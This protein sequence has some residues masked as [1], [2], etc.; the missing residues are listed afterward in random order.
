[1]ARSFFNVAAFNVRN[2]VNAE[3]TYYQRSRYSQ[4][5]Y[6]EKLT[7]L[8]EQLY[9]LDADFVCMQ[10]VFHSAALNDLLA[11][12]DALLAARHSPTKARLD[13][14]DTVH[15][16]PNI[17]E[18]ANNPQP[19]LAFLS[20]RTVHSYDAVQDL[21]ARPI[22]IPDDDGFSYGLTKLSRPV[23]I[24]KVDL[25]KGVSG[26]IFNAHLKSKLPRFPFGDPAADE[27]NALFLARTT[28]VFRSLALRAGEALAVR[29]E[30]LQRSQNS[31]D[32]VIVVGDL[33]DGIGAVSTEMVAGEAPWRRLPTDVKMK[34][35]DVELYS[36]VRSHLRRSEDASIY[37]HIYNG[38]YA[39]IDHILVSQEFYYRN[40][41]RIGDIHFVR[42]HNDHLT[43][44]SLDGAPSLG[45]ASDH[46]QLVARL[47]ID[48]DR[49]PVA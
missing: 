17:N 40:R 34:F 8:A 4:K 20:R 48:P 11:R 7:W 28:G 47:S 24:A 35:W 25:G 30:I 13:K 10:E 44:D 16:E 5:A 1:M 2:L 3:V 18:T 23:Q 41:D 14:Y 42:C 29:R 9:R 37:T 22:D 49:L 15:F 12:Y 6:D 45:P 26:W 38:A 32:P 36:A 46:G 19:G 27:A 21:T 39:T 43:D 33:N 31:T